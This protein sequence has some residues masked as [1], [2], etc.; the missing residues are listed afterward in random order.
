MTHR[1]QRAKV[2]NWE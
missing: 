2:N 1:Y